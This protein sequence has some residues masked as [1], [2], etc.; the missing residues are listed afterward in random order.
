MSDH[1]SLAADI[2]DEFVRNLLEHMGDSLKSI[3]LEGRGSL[4]TETRLRL[5]SQLS[6]IEINLIG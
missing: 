2:N 1:G 4:S 6:N 3:H 5:D